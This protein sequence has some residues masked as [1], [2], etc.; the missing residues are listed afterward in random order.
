[1]DC[2]DGYKQGISVFN[3]MTGKIRI[4]RDFRILRFEGQ[5][6]WPL[7]VGNSK[8][9]ANNFV[10]VAP[11]AG[12][13]AADLPTTHLMGGDPTVLPEEAH[14]AQVFIRE[15]DDETAA[16]QKEI[17]GVVDDAVDLGGMQDGVLLQEVQHSAA[18]A[19]S[20]AGQ[21]GSV[22][23]EV[24][25]PLVVPAVT[26]SLVPDMTEDLQP[27]D[28]KDFQPTTL[29]MDRIFTDSIDDKGQLLDGATFAYRLKAE[30][31]RSTQVF[32]EDVDDDDD[33]E[34]CTDDDL[35]GGNKQ[36]FTSYAD[37]FVG[38]LPS[39][40]AD[41]SASAK[42]KPETKKSIDAKQK[43]SPPPPPP[44]MSNAEKLHK[45]VAELR[46]ERKKMD[47]EVKK[48]RMMMKKQPKKV[49]SVDN[50]SLYKALQGP[51][52]Q[53][54]KEAID[55]EL[56]QYIETYEALD[57][58]DNDRLS[59]LSPEEVKNA[60][61]S[62]FEITYKRDRHTGALE[63]VKARLCIH[64]NETSKYDFDDVRSPTARTASMKLVIA[65]MAK[66]TPDG[67]QYNARSWDITGAFL[68][69]K[70][71]DR[72]R[73]KQ[74]RDPSFEEPATILLR[75]PDG[76]IGA[77]ASY[78]Y[79]LKQASL[80]F[81]DSVDELLKANGYLNTVDPCVYVKIVG[82]EKI[83]ITCHVDD[84]LAVSPS[85]ALLDEFGAMLSGKFGEDIT[86][87]RGDKLQYMGMVIERCLN[88]DVFVS[89]PAY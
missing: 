63:R 52:K 1:M 62:H 54:V 16:V 14:N 55:A 82:E 80:E 8:A 21:D 25:T 60:I 41:K 79:G 32:V 39:A 46:E 34:Y 33:D 11:I 85:E 53:L 51:Y 5:P 48:I 17:S 26:T 29:S 66:C 20:T 6:Q 2:P 84:F 75:L 22:M 69:T 24:N 47:A 74:S 76:R 27:Y 49:R 73:A 87:H 38:S 86:E 15:I 3:P 44:F 19:P 50:P 43:I 72:T 58:Y 67:R 18:L 65:M 36:F 37:A 40:S 68:Q 56:T 9:G 83:I 70:I 89:Q 10:P 7:Y 28:L 12:E 13:V 57:I 78:A 88:G 81:R 77:L 59:A 30:E 45:R 64:G 31:V 61:S 4:T 35:L 42:W 71:D 23:E